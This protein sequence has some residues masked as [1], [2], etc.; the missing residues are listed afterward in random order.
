M[1]TALNIF[2]TVTAEITTTDTV[3]YQAPTGFTGIILMAQVANISEENASVTFSHL[4]SSDNKTELIKSFTV[5]VNDATS[6]ITGKLILE[7]GSSVTVEGSSNDSL[8]ITLSV[9]ESLN[10]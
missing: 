7:D 5:P 10:A 2:K 6:V 9:L 4:D 3:I 8:K 1:A